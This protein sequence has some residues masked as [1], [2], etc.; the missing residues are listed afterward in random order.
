MSPLTHLDDLAVGRRRSE[1]PGCNRQ[2]S[3]KTV[4]R[5]RPTAPVAPTTVLMPSALFGTLLMG[6]GLSRRDFWSRWCRLGTLGDGLSVRASEV[7]QRNSM[8]RHRIHKSLVRMATATAT[9]GLEPRLSRQL[10]NE[11]GPS[12][13]PSPTATKGARENRRWNCVLGLGERHPEVCV[14]SLCV[15]ARFS[16]IEQREH[17]LTFHHR[18]TRLRLDTQTTSTPFDMAKPRAVASPTEDRE[19][20]RTTASDCIKVRHFFQQSG[21]WE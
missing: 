15:D 10:R 3:P 11:T 9:V 18:C 20:S 8:R 2:G 6:L 16:G 12:L 13:T 17:A 14:E 19:R 1:S 4:R 21:Y 7:C 5:S